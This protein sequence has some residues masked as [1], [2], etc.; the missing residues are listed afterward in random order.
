MVNL[1][2]LAA[3]LPNQEDRSCFERLVRLH[4]SDMVRVSKRILGN[5]ED[6]EDSAQEAFVKLYLN[7]EKYRSLGDDKMLALLYTITKNCA[8]NMYRKNSRQYDNVVYFGDDLDLIKI[9]SAFDS[10]LEDAIADLKE[11]DR[12]II[13]LKYVYGYDI[14]E[15]SDILDINS[16]AAYKR[17]ERAKGKLAVSLGE[18]LR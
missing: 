12:E 3:T 13:F 9:D 7:F 18:V 11:S 10:P 15:I 5:T 14:S 8:K 6:A 2:I 17:L 1:L 4:W 16:K